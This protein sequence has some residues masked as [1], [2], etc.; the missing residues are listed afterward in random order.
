MQNHRRFHS[1][2]GIVAGIFCLAMGVHCAGG[3]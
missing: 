3:R 1:R 2:G